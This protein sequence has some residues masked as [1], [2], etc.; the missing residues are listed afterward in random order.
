[1][2]DER[3]LVSTEFYND[4]C[5]PQGVFRPMTTWMVLAP[6]AMAKVGV[7]QQGT[8]NLLGPEDKPKLE[9]LVPH[10]TRALQLRRRL[11]AAERKSETGYAALDALAFGAMVCNAEGACVFVNEMAEM[12]ARS[13]TGLSLGGH[14]KPVTAAMSKEGT[15]LRRL[16]RDAAMGG[17]GGTMQLSNGEGAV[18]LLLLVSHLPN[19]FREGEGRGLALVALRSVQDAPAFS[20]ALLAAMFKLSP[21]QAALAW[22]LSAGSSLEEAAMER[23]VKITTARSQLS[24]IFNKTG[25]ENQRDLLR[26]I[27]QIPPV[28][29]R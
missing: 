28:R 6:G 16:I 3:E 10:L 13:G 2:F 26:I 27:G 17:A 7:Q 4:F 23:G 25:A 29:F 18:S 21:A 22:K 15:Q 5:R 11:A 9:G 1:L 12:L 19:R 24:D 8:N 20:E 14:G